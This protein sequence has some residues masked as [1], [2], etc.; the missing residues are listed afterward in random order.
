MQQRESMDSAICTDT[1][2]FS[3]ITVSCKHIETILIERK[4]W[5]YGPNPDCVSPPEPA[6][7]PAA[8]KFILSSRLPPFQ[9]TAFWLFWSQATFYFTIRNKY[10]GKG[11]NIQPQAPSYPR[12]MITIFGFSCPR[13][14][15]LGTIQLTCSPHYNEGKNTQSLL[16][17]GKQQQSPT[18]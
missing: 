14:V 10:Q 3:G 15:H 16:L 18:C 5:V 11:G 17:C 13:L 6:K 1:W 8:F 2:C 12:R 7:V 9:T 4:T